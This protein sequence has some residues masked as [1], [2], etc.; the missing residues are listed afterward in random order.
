MSESTN[1]DNFYP[2]DE[3][4]IDLIK[5][6]HWIWRR[7]CPINGTVIKTKDDHSD[8]SPGTWK[9]TRV[10]IKRK[11]EEQVWINCNVYPCSNL[12]I[13]QIVKRKFFGRLYYDRNYTFVVIERF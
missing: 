8:H 1:N 12:N 5:L 10:L 9:T 11:N 6:P 3:M 2:L 7:I 13:G 4:F